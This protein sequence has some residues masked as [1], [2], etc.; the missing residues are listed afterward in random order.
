MIERKKAEWYISHDLGKKI[1][2]EPFV[3]R[4]NFEPQS[5]ANGEVGKYYLKP[6]ENI[7]VVCGNDQN[8]IRKNIV[9]REYRKNFPRKF[10]N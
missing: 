1:K 4:L 8:L 2:D 6:K 7:C 3:V 5:R 10:F 9:P